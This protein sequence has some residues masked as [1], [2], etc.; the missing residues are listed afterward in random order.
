MKPVTLL[1][2][3]RS[4][5]IYLSKRERRYNS[6]ASRDREEPPLIHRSSQSP[7]SKGEHGCSNIRRDMN[8]HGEIRNNKIVLITVSQNK[9]KWGQVGIFQRTEREDEK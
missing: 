9:S 1:W 4:M 7:I 2:P 8:S 5:R 6:V 3:P